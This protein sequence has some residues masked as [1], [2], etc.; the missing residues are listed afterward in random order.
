MI[1]R[2]SILALASFAAAVP[3][4]PMQLAASIESAVARP[5][6]TYTDKA[7][8][9]LQNGQP[10]DCGLYD[11]DTDLVVGL[12]TTFYNS[13]D[14]SSY[15]G[16]YVV[17]TNLANN[18]TVTS[19]VAT[20]SG[21]N[22]TIALSVAAW[23]KVNG[24][25][26]NFTTAAWRFANTSET[27]AAKAALIDGSSDSS[28]SSSSSETYA[29]A[30]TTT[31]QANQN[32]QAQT[33]TKPTTTTYQQQTTTYQAPATT[34]TKASSSGSG[35]SFS[36]QATWFTQNGVAGA[37]GSVNSD[38]SYIVALDSAIYSGGSHCGQSVY[39]CSGGNC[40]TAKVADECPTCASAYSLD[41]STGA[42]Q[43]LGSLGAGVLSITWSWA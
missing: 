39:I 31:T 10:G 16:A 2:L 21:V 20:S 13:S 38:S 24:D 26:T 41:L 8:W 29:A 3:I 18:E 35:G 25:N 6:T 28:S 42:F 17:V 43:A 15:C 1:A 5:N 14:I 23:R 40:I 34:T 9:Y 33:T 32:Y 19:R 4:A 7:S 36:G 11:Q 30:A 37:C 27:A 12:P 22:D